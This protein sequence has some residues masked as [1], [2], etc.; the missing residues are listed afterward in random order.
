M[1]R[2]PP[3][4]YSTYLR[5]QND[6]SVT[7]TNITIYV[8]YSIMNAHVAVPNT[9]QGFPTNMSITVNGTYLFFIHIDFGDNSSVQ[10]SSINTNLHILRYHQNYGPPWYIVYTSHVYREMGVYDVRFNISNHV[11]YIL[12]YSEA[13][14]EEA[15][16][17]V[18]LETNSTQNVR[19]L[20]N[21]RVKATVA[22][23]KNLNFHW[24]FGD[25]YITNVQRYVCK[26]R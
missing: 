2:F 10:L 24:D 19:L 1:G 13:V 26:R 9:V 7:S 4:I 11:S 14:V 25:F 17:G 22:T 12:A 18:Q 5:A 3:G 6:I 20:T 23:G 8:Q 15:I 21:V 16:T